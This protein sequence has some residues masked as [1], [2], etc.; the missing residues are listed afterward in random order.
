MLNLSQTY[1]GVLNTLSFWRIL[2]LQDSKRKIL[3]KSIHSYQNVQ[4]ALTF[5]ANSERLMIPGYGTKHLVR[6][7]LDTQT[8]GPL[9]SPNDHENFFLAA[10]T[11]NDS[12]FDVQNNAIR[13]KIWLSIH[14]A[15]VVDPNFPQ[16]TSVTSP[17]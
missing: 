5:S 8:L 11:S 6:I 3:S 15:I 12:P 10:I 9:F 2:W 4:D 7:F 13:G 14:D 1:S 16:L 17:V